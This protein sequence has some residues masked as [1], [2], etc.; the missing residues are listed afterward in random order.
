M[1]DTTDRAFLGVPIEPGTGGVV[2]PDPIGLNKPLVMR[3]HRIFTGDKDE[4][5]VLITSAVKAASSNDAAPQAM[6]GVRKGVKPQHFLPFGATDPGSPYLYYSKAAL[7]TSVSV[8]VRLSW[9]RFDEKRYDRYVDLLGKTAALPVF[10]ASSGV[11]G[12]AGAL[13]S[14]AAIAVVGKAVKVVLHA[15]D[16]WVDGDDDK[17]FIANFDLNLEVPGL[18]RA[19]AGWVL[20]RDDDES[21]EILVSP[22]GEWTKEKAVQGP[23]D[24]LFYVNDNGDLCYKDG[25]RVVD[26]LD[27]P[28]VL[29]HVSGTETEELDGFAPAAATAV[30]LQ[31]FQ[32]AEGDALEDLTDLVAA[33]N[34]VTMARRA[35]T[36]D[37][38][39]KDASG[40][41]KDKLVEQRKAV[42]K[43]IQ[44]E[45]IRR[46]VPTT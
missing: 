3:I 32:Q 8:Q 15:V 22:D 7:N 1:T 6:H 28:Y 27:Q 23:D 43:Q 40:E 13:G 29:I 42:I 25:D 14:G 21:H 38:K 45:D 41:E 9:D 35:A 4:G 11:F 39:I 20:L 12:P 30:L 24:S 16:R 18:A 10:A 2:E 31:Q 46:L 26:D 37:E 36:L 33:Y 34:D 5:Q 19:K 17:D 44:D